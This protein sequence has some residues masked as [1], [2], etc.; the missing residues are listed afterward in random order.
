M[1]PHGASTESAADRKHQNALRSFLA[2]W[3]AED[4]RIAGQARLSAFLK[5]ILVH[6]LDDGRPVGQLLA[7]TGTTD[8]VDAHLVI[9][10]ERLGRDILTAW[11]NDCVLWR[12]IIVSRK[13]RLGRAVKDGGGLDGVFR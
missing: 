5:T 6:S 7:Q 13:W 2:E 3:D 8:L 4:G 12:P 1:S 9:T 11:G 10:A